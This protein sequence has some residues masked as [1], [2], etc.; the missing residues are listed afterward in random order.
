VVPLFEKQ[1]SE[2]GPVTVT[3]KDIT[4]YFM[5]IPEA[6]SLILQAGAMGKGE[7]IFVLD[8]GEPVRIQ[9]L[10][11]QMIHIAGLTPGKDIEIVFTG[12]RPGEKL[13]EEIFHERENLQSTQH[14]K[15]FL[16]G[17]RKVDWHWLTNELDNLTKAATSRDVPSLISHL[18]R[19]VPEYKGVHVSDVQELTTTALKVVKG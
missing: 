15:L 13:Y 2:G 16:A 1:I 3:H 11:E 12:L 6:V 4:R 17:S 7:E 5:T 10:A 9:D 14:A 19:I 8:M 18:R